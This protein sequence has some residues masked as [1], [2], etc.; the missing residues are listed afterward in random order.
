MIEM[1]QYTPN[2]NLD[3]YED[4]DKPNLRDQYN[5]AMGK[6][7][8]QLANIADVASADITTDRIVNGAVTTAKLAD[9]A[10]TADKL[11]EGAVATENMQAYCVTSDKIAIGAVGNSQLGSNS[12]GNTTLADNAVSS[13]KIQS[14]AITKEKIASGVLP[15]IATR[16]E[17]YDFGGTT[18]QPGDSYQI[19]HTFSFING[20]TTINIS[21]CSATNPN[22]SP[23]A[24][25]YA[26][27][28][29]SFT[30][31]QTPGYEGVAVTFEIV[32]VTDSPIVVSRLNVTFVD[33]VL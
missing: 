3:L 6:I 13:N 17:T 19:N 25:L 28:K 16:S 23:V 15:E 4:T 22:G 14:Q 20:Q 32:N 9:G 5:A 24:P 31:Q 30:N 26:I 8:T 2:Y 1:T 12:V 11:G 10:V 7:D 29:L 27:K 21:S 33:L 18:I